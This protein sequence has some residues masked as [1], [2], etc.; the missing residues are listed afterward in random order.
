MKILLRTSILT[1]VFIFALLIFN[2]FVN[3]D[4]LTSYEY[5][6][7][8]LKPDWGA[9][10]THYK[11]GEDT[12][13]LLRPGDCDCDG[14][15][16]EADARKCLRRVARLDDDFSYDPYQ[17]FS[18]F[19]YNSDGVLTAVDARQILRV[20]SKMD[21]AED[22]IITGETN[23]KYY[24]T[25][26]RVNPGEDREWTAVS[27]KKSV[28]IT[29]YPYYP[30]E[31][32]I[33]KQTGFEIEFSTKKLGKYKVKYECRN[34]KTGEVVDSFCVIYNINSTYDEF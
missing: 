19:D 30:D 31:N 26:I 34:K 7:G 12:K 18:S 3:K 32:S 16:T 14:E 20:A 9:I 11:D 10:I 4:E 2:S 24:M 28:S 8:G 17:Y 1:I 25:G 13:F 5:A 29:V 21:P 22:M 33:N 27:N 15:V 23:V 6:M